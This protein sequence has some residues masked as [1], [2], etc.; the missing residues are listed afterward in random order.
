[1]NRPTATKSMTEASII[2]EWEEQRNPL[3]GGSAIA[4]YGLQY[5]Q[6]EAGAEW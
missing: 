2:L 4:S 6:A 3:D 5:K 1:M